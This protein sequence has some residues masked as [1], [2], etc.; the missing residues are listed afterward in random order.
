[1]WSLFFNYHAHV[2]KMNHKHSIPS[3]QED[4]RIEEFA[5]QGRDKLKL[6]CKTH[7]CQTQHVMVSSPP[8]MLK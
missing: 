8:W 7:A 2:V 3:D 1:M 6:S 5:D 4:K